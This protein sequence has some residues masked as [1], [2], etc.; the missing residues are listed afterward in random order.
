MTRLEQAGRALEQHYAAVPE[1]GERVA[2]RAVVAVRGGG[3]QGERGQ[4]RQA[5]RA[6]NEDQ[7]H[8]GL[9]PGDQGTGAHGTEDEGERAPQPDAPVVEAL[10]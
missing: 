8:I 1:Q 6:Q 4:H 10:A 9:A 5:K 3:G 7:H 2:R